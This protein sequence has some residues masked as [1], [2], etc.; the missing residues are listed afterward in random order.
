MSK[1]KLRPRS[2]ATHPA[3]TTPATTVDDD[4]ADLPS[5]AGNGSTDSVPKPSLVSLFDRK[6]KIGEEISE[7]EARILEL[8]EEESSLAT[9]V[10]THYGIGPYE[11]DGKT[12]KVRGQ[13]RTGRMI[14]ADAG[15]SDVIKVR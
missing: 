8:Q 5:T 11:W 10:R 3:H 12:Y 1:K 6:V 2:H 7:C 14:F 13:N 9:E 15:M 4:N